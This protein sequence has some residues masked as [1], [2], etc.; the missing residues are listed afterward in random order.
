[1]LVVSHN[2]RR[3][4]VQVILIALAIALISY[5]PVRTIFNIATKGSIR[6]ES[7]SPVSEAVGLRP[8]VGLPHVA[9]LD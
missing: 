5:V 4:P 9:L 7:A 3:S 6:A 2:N 1:M 8:D